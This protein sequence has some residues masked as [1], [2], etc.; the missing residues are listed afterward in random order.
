L[1]VS[2]SFVNYIID[3]LMPLGPTVRKMFGGA[4]IYFE[5]SMFGLIADDILYLK[6]ND[7]T[8]QDYEQQGMVP[9]KPFAHKPMVMPYYEIPVEVLENSSLLITWA[10]KAIVVAKSSPKKKRK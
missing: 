3:Q 4:G 6:V 7:V 5:G 2:D 8:K 9:F 1:T 10:E